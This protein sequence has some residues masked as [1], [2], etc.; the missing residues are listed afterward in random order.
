MYERVTRR[1]HRQQNNRHILRE[2]KR[3]KM[4]SKGTEEIVYG[5]RAKLRS[6]IGKLYVSE[7]RGTKGEILSLI[8]EGF[9]L[10]RSYTPHL[11]GYHGGGQFIATVEEMYKDDW[12][13]F[14]DESS[15]DSHAHC[16]SERHVTAMALEGR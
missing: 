5:E 6:I 2:K 15:W 14:D 7:G 4:I 10:C 9:Y 16:T 12:Q 8:K 1:A 13:F 3:R 11:D